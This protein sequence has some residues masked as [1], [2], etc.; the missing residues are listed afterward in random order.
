M[1]NSHV[2]HVLPSSPSKSLDQKEHCLYIQGH[3]TLQKTMSESFQK[4]S[5]FPSQEA[6]LRRVCSLQVLCP[7]W[8]PAKE[9]RGC[10]P[11]SKSPSIFLG[12]WAMC[13]H[14]SLLGWE[15]GKIR[16]WCYRMDCVSPT[17][18][19]YVEALTLH[20]T[21]FGDRTCKEIIR[22][23]WGHKSGA[24]YNRAFF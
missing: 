22:V 23:T 3:L 17:P 18:N 11:F 14:S 24:R 13:F 16:A 4:Y 7:K 15:K 2:L 10:F 8:T 6:T 12:D 19:S 20:V 9:D 21:V 5:L 1:I